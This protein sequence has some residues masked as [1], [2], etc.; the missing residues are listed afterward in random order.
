MPNKSRFG[1]VGPNLT[2]SYGTDV[3]NPALAAGVAVVAGAAFNTVALP[4]GANVRALGVTAV[5]TQNAGDPV[6]VV[7]FGEC[8][9]IADMAIAR[10]Q[11]VG[12]NA[13]TG[14]LAPVGSG[15]LV[16]GE[17]EI[18]GLALEAAT[19]QGDEFLCFVLPHRM[20]DNTSSPTF[21]SLTLTALLNESSTDN[22]VAH[23]GGGQA[24]ATALTKEINRVITVATAG[25]SVALP[26]S[27]PGLTIMVV[28]HGANPLQVF[29]TGADTINDVAAATGVTQMQGSL[30][31]YSCITAGAWYTEGLGTGYS[32]AF[33]TSSYTNGIVAHAGGGQ[34]SGTL[35]TTVLNRVIT[36]ATIGDSVLL[37]ASVPGMQ[38]TVANG[39]AN[40]LNLFPA[41]GDQINALGANAAFAIAG[42]KTATLYCMV[43]GQWHAVLSA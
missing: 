43:A 39:A 7:E 22:I 40:S 11:W 20:L 28:N 21:A 34:G 27:A 32:G 18:V 14:Q 25:D 6:S 42:G 26:A 5:P 15:N 36:V 19:Q 13:A 10:N 16:G 4:G 31:I 23:A 30:V 1:P 24:Q 3:A 8:T 33:P 37:P 41:V 35:V 17:I 12:V 38:I 29:G 2:R 9:A